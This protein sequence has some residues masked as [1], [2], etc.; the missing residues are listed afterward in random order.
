MSRVFADTSYYLALVN[1]RDVFHPAACAL[2]ADF[3]GELVTTAWVITELGNFLATGS[4]R[5]VF[6]DLLADLRS[7]NR[8]TILPPTTPGLEEGL[9]LYGRRADKDWSV[10]DCISFVAVEQ[11]GL[12]EAFTTDHHFAQAGFQ[13]LLRGE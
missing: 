1:P 8:V 3:D 13:V 5:R 6:V 9:A 2:T 12:R 4:N 11:Q 7:D 10:T